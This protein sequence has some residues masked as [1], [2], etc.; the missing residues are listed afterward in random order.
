[1]QMIEAKSDIDK[2]KQHNARVAFSNIFHY[3]QEVSRERPILICIP[4]I[5]RFSEDF[6]LFIDQLLHEV[7]LQQPAIRF[8]ISRNADLFLSKKRADILK[9]ILD[10]TTSSCLAVRPFNSDLVVTLQTELFGRTLFSDKELRA[11]IS[12]TEGIPLLV[13]EFIKH[14]VTR[15]IIKFENG[16]WHLDRSAL[17]ETA[18]PKSIYALIEE[19]YITLPREEKTLAQIVALWGRPILYEELHGLCGFEHRMLESTLVKL[20]TKLVLKQT[21]ENEYYFV[22]PA[23]SR[24]VREKTSKSKAVKI[25]QI[26]V[27]LVEKTDKKNYERLALHCIEAR[28]VEKA[29]KYGLLAADILDKRLELYRCHELLEKLE[30]L[31]AKNG[32]REQQLL[33][34]EKLAPIEQRAGYIDKA[35]THY[36]QL[37]NNA[38]SDTE[39][40]LHMRAL[41]R[42][43]SHYWGE[44]K[45]AAALYRDAL[46]H[47]TPDGNPNIIAEILI[48][49]TAVEPENTIELLQRAAQLTRGT[50]YNLYSK[51]TASLLRAYTHSGATEN[52]DALKEEL[53]DLLGVVGPVYKSFALHCL[54]IAEFFAGKY[55][56]ARKYAEEEIMTDIELCDEVGLGSSYNNLGGI[57]YVQGNF[58][59]QI[60]ILRKAINQQLKYSRYHAA[61]NLG[62]ISLVYRCV[63]DYREGLR[64][65]ERAF[66]LYENFMT[67]T[68]GEFVLLKSTS[69]Y[70]MLGEKLKDKY[71][72]HMKKTEAAAKRHN[73]MIVIA[74]TQLL[75]ARYY[76][77]RLAMGQAIRHA[78]EAIRIFDRAADKDDLVDSRTQMGIIFLERGD[79]REAESY[80][81]QAR[82]I[83]NDIHCE[84]LNPQLLYAEGVQARVIKLATAK[85][86][87]LAALKTS[88]KMFTR[89]YTWQIQRELALYH[90]EKGELHKALQYYRDAIDM[91]KEI[92]ETIDGDE[93]KASYLALPFRKRV[94][95]EIKILKQQ[96]N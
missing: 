54:S 57:H 3:L 29:C 60:N 12:E 41:A 32:T 93:V 48:D 26:I 18:I 94:F 10:I 45:R 46:K 14:L 7:R 95:D 62:N 27:S 90:K 44:Q 47:A 8:I 11:L 23:Y 91:I 69:L 6:F 13:V 1:M 53:N 68:L 9:N 17:G 2:D 36:D 65:I 50:N 78:R 87:L 67:A 92:T 64:A 21:G 72:E 73:N 16:L 61:Y 76:Y 38:K 52:V 35:Y 22:H 37:L 15:N 40:A 4:D 20:E 56:N 86:K 5:E 84:Y 96:L 24:F 59:D 79:I 51:A 81:S 42:I 88:K 74:H 89:E 34:L 80:L 85:E 70:L 77:Q 33:I 82:N 30:S 25:A 43:H 75:K 83:Y 63:A 58:Y 31:V 39:R 28:L 49:M 19:E 71:M 55:D 66:D